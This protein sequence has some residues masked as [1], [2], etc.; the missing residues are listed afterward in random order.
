MSLTILCVTA[1]R[2]VKLH[3]FSFVEALGIESKQLECPNSFSLPPYILIRTGLKNGDRHKV[4]GRLMLVEGDQMFR[5]L[6]EVLACLMVG[7]V[8]CPPQGHWL[9]LSFTG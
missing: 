2:L 4:L 1:D 8:V 7:F 9:L 6:T 3:L 5:H